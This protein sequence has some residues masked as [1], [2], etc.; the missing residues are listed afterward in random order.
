MLHSL[1]LYNWS[2]IVNKKEFSNKEVEELDRHS[3][4]LM[5]LSKIAHTQMEKTKDKD[6]KDFWNGKKLKYKLMSIQTT[7]KALLYCM[8]QV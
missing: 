5:T 4:A 1:I 3:E 6:E 8:T 7:E 2:N